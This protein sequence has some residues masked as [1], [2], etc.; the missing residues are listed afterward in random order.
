MN[1]YFSALSAH[2]GQ[3]VEVLGRRKRQWQVATGL[4]YGQ[5]KKV[6][7]RR[8]VVRVTLVMR[9][10][11]RMA[12]RTGLQT[13]GLSGRLNTAVIERVK[14]DGAPKCRRTGPP[15]LVNAVAGAAVAGPSGV[16]AGVRAFCPAAPVVTGDTRTAA[17]PRW[18]TSAPAVP[19]PESG[20]G[21]LLDEPA[22]ERRRSP[23]DSAPAGAVR[24]DLSM[25]RRGQRARGEREMHPHTVVAGRGTAS[26]SG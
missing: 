22:L 19:A 15:H 20:A 12:L 25:G 9:W 7:R 26:S 23:G 21:R 5:V 11:T 13:L 18:E 4:I 17:G 8:K 24:R 16:V 3:W 14:K 6:Y 1:L 2:F 10:G